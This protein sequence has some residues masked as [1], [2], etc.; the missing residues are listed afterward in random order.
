[1]GVDPAVVIRIARRTTTQEKG[2]QFREMYYQLEKDEKLACSQVFVA[3]YLVRFYG[4]A[5]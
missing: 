1:M 5:S 3:S 4:G 2:K